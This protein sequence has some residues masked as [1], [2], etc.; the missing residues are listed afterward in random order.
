[1]REPQLIVIFIVLIFL[2][3]NILV[4]RTGFVKPKSIEDYAV[5]GR[6]LKWIQV[7][8]SYIGA[9]FVGATYT[10]WF[11]TAVN[12]GIFAQYLVLYALG[13]LVLV[14]IL[15]KPVWTMGKK[16]NLLT[17]ADF[18]ELRYQNRAFKMFYSLFTF[19]FWVPWL[20]I[21]LKTAGY[22]L[23]V[24]TR[25]L[26]NFELGITIIAL[27]ITVYCYYGGARACAVGSLYQVCI[28]IFL[29]G[30]LVYFLI[31]EAYGGIIPLYE[32]VSSQKPEL[33]SLE[34]SWNAN[35]FVSSMLTGTLGAFCWPDEFTHLYRAESPAAMQ[36]TILLVPFAVIAVAFLPLMLGLG[37]GLLPG[38]PADASRGILWL[39]EHFGGALGLA[40][41]AVVVLAACISTI[42]SIINAASII[43][44]NDFQYTGRKLSPQA[45]LKNAKATTIVVGL[46]SLWLA[47][48]QLPKLI[49]IEFIL[50][51]CIVQAA[52]PLLFGLYWKKG[53][54][55]G[56]VAGMLTGSVIAIFGVLHPSAFTWSNGWSTGMIGFCV[57]CFL[58]VMFAY[59]N[60]D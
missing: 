36:R 19:A 20:V 17:L 34:G 14:Y 55:T 54:I 29:G 38:F 35:L 6:S 59:M 57:N 3:I 13:G 11:A 56:A 23:S 21:E 24:A 22:I 8:F 4:L 58:Y 9:W 30:W 39:A 18:I 51:N 37:A 33:F 27:F 53:N 16:H 5:A 31:R 48:I 42:A 25:N 45:A 26:I 2:G 12:Y 52:V 41:M 40:M 32:F 46:L 43:I 10:D 47:T 44:V 1:M 7:A 28:F 50:Y 49:I 60:V 15:A